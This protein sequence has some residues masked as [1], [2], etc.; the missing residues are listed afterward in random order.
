[1]KMNIKQAQKYVTT[2]LADVYSNSELISIKRELL[3]YAT[4]LNSA[5]QILADAD[6]LTPEQVE[7]LAEQINQLKAGEPLQYI[8]GQAYFYDRIFKV[9]K[10]VL[11]PRP[12]TE[13]LIEWI[14]E[15]SLN[16][17]KNILDIGT[18]SGC[19]AIILNKIFHGATVYAIDVSADALQVAQDNAKEHDAKIEFIQA[20]I[21]SYTSPIIQFD[22]IVSNPPYVPE[23]EKEEMQTQVLHF[24]PH[25]ALF[26][27]NHNPL[28]FY[29]HITNFA[30]QYL[31][32]GGELYFETHY[33]YASEV[34]KYME[35][36]GFVKVEIKKDLSGK[37]RMV[38]GIKK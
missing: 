16:A 30:I 9:N 34:K 10:N 14:K 15:D 4:G 7:K 32:A 19:I 33:L 11:I 31:K 25:I 38:K 37:D 6:Y 20:D 29:T 28:K 5:Q 18:G 17:K 21:F 36:A 24:E 26:V 35:Q 13:E 22:I 1:M 12:E 3:E 27:P 23:S 2:E 8:L